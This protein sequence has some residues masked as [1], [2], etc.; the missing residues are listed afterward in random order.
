MSVLHAMPEVSGATFSMVRGF[1]RGRHSAENGHGAGCSASSTPK[2][3]LE[4][5]VPG[6]VADHVR[7][8]I[9]AAAHTGKRGD[10]KVFI[11]P[12][13]LAVRISSGE[14]GDWAV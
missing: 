9:Q 12:V 5:V 1:G 7:R 6:A 3:R 8:A 10:G 11:L 14:E 2:V 13:E 4:V